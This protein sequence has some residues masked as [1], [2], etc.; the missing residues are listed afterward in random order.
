MENI[1]SLQKIEN[2]LFHLSPDKTKKYYSDFERFNLAYQNISVSKIKNL[3][4]ENLKNDE[5]FLMAFDI[6]EKQIIEYPQPDNLK[7]IKTKLQNSK[8]RKLLFKF[9]KSKNDSNLKESDD[10]QIFKNL[11]ELI[12]NFFNN[13]DKIVEFLIQKVVNYFKKIN[14]QDK[15]FQIMKKFYSLNFLKIFGNKKFHGILTLYKNYKES[16]IGDIEKTSFLEPVN[17]KEMFFHYL[18]TNI[19]EDLKNKSANEIFDEIYKQKEEKF[20]SIIYGIKKLLKSFKTI[21]NF[22]VTKYD[23]KN[24]T[25]LAFIVVHYLD[26]GFAEYFRHV[27]LYPLELI[28]QTKKQFD[29]FFETYTTIVQKLFGKVKIVNE[30]NIIFEQ[31]DFLLYYFGISKCGIDQHLLK[32]NVPLVNL[33]V[34]PYTIFY[35]DYFQSLDEYFPSPEISYSK[36]NKNFFNFKLLNYENKKQKNEK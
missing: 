34:I 35:E 16:L 15:I 33:N 21:S 12:K 18:T 20:D 31:L 14:S 36:F 24:K 29:Y 8:I 3:I 25:D 30:G 17:I 23:F 26:L 10:N 4:G 2:Q 32:K 5:G 22:I 13:C 1:K 6:S 28:G 7:S 27:F 19:L 11:S 9:I